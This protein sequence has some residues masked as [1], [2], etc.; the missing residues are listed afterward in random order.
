M[1]YMKDYISRQLKEIKEYETIFTIFVTCLRADG[2]TY[3]RFRA[4]KYKEHSDQIDLP[5]LSKNHLN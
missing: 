4:I 1:D 2:M 3:Q 5:F